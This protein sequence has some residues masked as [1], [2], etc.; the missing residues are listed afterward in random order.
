MSQP[1]IR[2]HGDGAFHQDI[3]ARHLTADEYEALPTDLRAIVRE[4]PLYDYAGY[5]EKAQATK[6]TPSAP[7]A[8][9]AEKAQD[10]A[11]DDKATKSS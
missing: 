5:R 9:A 8:K 11:P 6:D 1:T 2:Y 7:P 10:A 4:S 3:P